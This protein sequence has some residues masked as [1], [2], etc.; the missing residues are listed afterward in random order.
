[1]NKVDLIE[2]RDEIGMLGKSASQKQLARLIDGRI[3]KLSPT[4][5]WRERAEAEIERRGA[6]LRATLG[7]TVVATERFAGFRP[8]A[9]GAVTVLA[10]RRLPRDHPVVGAYPERFRALTTRAIDREVY[11]RVRGW[12]SVVGLSVTG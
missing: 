10:G 9:G 5:V 1:M 6:E 4:A 8:G 2:I 7:E 12:R 3:A 11:F